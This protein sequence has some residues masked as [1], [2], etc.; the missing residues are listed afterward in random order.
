MK[1]I[2]VLDI[3]NGQAVYAVGGD[4]A[5]YAPLQSDYFPDAT[6]KGMVAQ[7]ADNGFDLLYC[8]DLD[9]IAG[10]RGNGAAIERALA[11][12][13]ARLQCWLD[14]GITQFADYQRVKSLHPTVIPVLGSET[15]YDI[16]LAQR[17]KEQEQ[18]FVLSLD[19]KGGQLLGK[20]HLLRHPEHWPAEVI[21]LSLDAVGCRQG[22]D[23]RCLQAVQSL[24]PQQALVYGGGV[25]NRHDLDKLEALNIQATLVASSLYHSS[26]Q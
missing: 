24:A 3:K 26:A 11:R 9:A 4:R 1:C 5:R 10:K 14:A 18:A 17:L 16:H 20:R 19:F 12:Q 15:L 25:R 8:A 22:P 6:L 13:A 2:P 23:W 7:I 21:V